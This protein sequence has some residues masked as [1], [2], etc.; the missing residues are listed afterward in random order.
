MSLG[1]PNGIESSVSKNSKQRRTFLKIASAGAAIA[2]IPGHSA[3]AGIAGSIVAS[4]HGSDWN[5]GNCIILRSHGCWKRTI[6][7]AEVS[8]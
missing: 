5:G 7:W 3:W 1:N 4:G 8:E 6:N 2:S